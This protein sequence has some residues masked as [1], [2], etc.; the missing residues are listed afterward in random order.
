MICNGNF[1][2]LKLKLITSS[3]QYIINF[4]SK[5]K[6]FEVVIFTVYSHGF[7]FIRRFDTLS[8]LLLIV[9]FFSIPLII[10]FDK[11]GLSFSSTILIDNFVFL[12][13]K[14]YSKVSIWLIATGFVSIKIQETGSYASN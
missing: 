4:C 12:K 2:V 11:T 1:C 10:K 5:E 14:L 7:K 6:L 3:H 13:I 9:F 8:L